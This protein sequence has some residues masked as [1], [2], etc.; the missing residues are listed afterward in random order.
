MPEDIIKLGMFGGVGGR[1]LRSFAHFASGQIPL[2]PL[3]A[4]A[5][6][7]LK[8]AVLAF[9]M[10]TP[11]A[12]SA[13]RYVLQASA[14]GHLLC[15]LIALLA[16]LA[17]WVSSLDHQWTEKG[18]GFDKGMCWAYAYF[19]YPTNLSIPAYMSLQF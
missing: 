8:C 12:L 7:G 5:T 2:L 6:A 11:L 1:W 17:S 18:A 10:A 15:S 13:S 3:V 14:L 16:F 9:L 19:I 4:S